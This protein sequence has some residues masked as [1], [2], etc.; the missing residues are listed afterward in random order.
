MSCQRDSNT[1]VVLGRFCLLHPLSKYSLTSGEY[2][3]LSG[4]LE[5]PTLETLGDQEQERSVTCHRMMHLDPEL[6]TVAEVS[7]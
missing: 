2:R 7:N 4:S 3:E 1:E 6:G 5:L